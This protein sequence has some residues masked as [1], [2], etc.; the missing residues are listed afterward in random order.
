MTGHLD[1]LDEC[2]ECGAVLTQTGYDAQACACGWGPFAVPSNVV[3][4]FRAAQPK[5]PSDEAIA[6]AFWRHVARDPDF[7]NRLARWHAAAR[8]IVQAAW[9]YDREAMRR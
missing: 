3:S 6:A 7:I 8:Q 5:R 9:D 1:K 4:P 2:P